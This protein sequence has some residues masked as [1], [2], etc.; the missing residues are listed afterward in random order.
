MSLNTYEFD[1]VSEMS[2]FLRGGISGGARVFGPAARIQNLNG[3]TLIFLKPVAGTVTFVDTTGDGLT[4]PAVASQITSVMTGLSV[5]WKNQCLSLVEIV[6]IAGVSL[7]KSGTANTVFGF[8][9]ASN[10][11]NVAFNG[12]TG[13]TPRFIECGSKPRLDGLY[14]VVEY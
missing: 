1:T 12:P 13:D 2:F 3:A 5:L 11:G 14:V 6:P 7:S 9:T 4:A 10:T 8:T